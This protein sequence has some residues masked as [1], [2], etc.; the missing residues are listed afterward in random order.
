VCCIH[1]QLH[2][3]AYAAAIIRWRSWLRH[4]ATSRKAA[5]SIP[6]EA[7]EIFN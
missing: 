6:D 2:A 5:G 7:I 1:S 4:W 3:S